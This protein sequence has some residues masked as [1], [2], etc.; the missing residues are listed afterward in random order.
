SESTRSSPSWWSWTTTPGASSSWR[1]GMTTSPRGGGRGWSRR[2]PGSM[3]T[4]WRCTQTSRIRARRRRRDWRRSWAGAARGWGAGGAACVSEEVDDA[5]A[6]SETP[7]AAL[8][9]ELI[10]AEQAVADSGGAQYV[11]LTSYLCN[12][13]TCP[14]IIGNTLVY[15]DGPHLS[16]RFSEQMAP[17]LWE[18][19]GEQLG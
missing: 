2:S 9:P 12:D 17:P 11:D 18:E 6:C 3:D 8:S 1:E 7:A 5:G 19:L 4:R 16:A 10:E 14:T 15:R 13:Q